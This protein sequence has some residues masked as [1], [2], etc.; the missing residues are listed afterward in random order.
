MTDVRL[1]C[2]RSTCC[3]DDGW[4]FCGLSA[5]A[6]AFGLTGDE[7]GWVG[8]GRRMNK[9]DVDGELGTLAFPFAAFIGEGERADFVGDADRDFTRGLDI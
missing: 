3:D 9:V 4:A 5:R 8:E 1:E 6:S 7:G 2:V